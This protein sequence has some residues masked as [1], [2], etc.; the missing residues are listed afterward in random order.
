MRF[1]RFALLSVS[2]LAF[3]RAAETATPAPRDPARIA[4][5]FC[6]NC[7]GQQLLGGSGPNLLDSFWNHGGDEAS[8]LRSI[9]RGYP[10]SGMPPLAEVFSEAELKAMI[11]FIK[12]QGAEFAAGRIKL[13]EAPAA[14]TIESEKALFRLETV[15][16][17]LDMPWGIAFLPNDQIVVTERPGRLRLITKGQLVP[18]PITG[19]PEVF[20][21]QDGGLLD[22]IAHPDYAKNGW[23]YL[24]Y[25]DEGKV[26]NTSMTVV[27]R[28]KIRDGRWVEQQEI[29]RAAPEHYHRSYIHYGC[30][31][32]FD[33]DNHLFFTIGDR[34]EPTEAQDLASPC[35]KIHRVMDDGR[36]PADNPFAKQAGAFGSIWSYGNRHVQ[37][38]QYHPVTGK[39]WATEH[40]PDNG[41][42]LNR[43]EG[44]RNYGWPTISMGTDRRAPIQGTSREG[45]ESPL[46]WWTPAIAPSGIE[47]YAGDKFPQWKN[48]LFVAALAGQQLRRIETDGDRVTHQEV[49]FKG[50]GRVRDVVTGP[51]GFLYVAFNGPGRIARL[52]P[53]T[54][55]GAVAA[56]S[57]ARVEKTTFGQMPDGTDVDIYTL[58]NRHGSFAKILTYGA[59]VA[60][61]RV[62]DRNGRVG[63]VIR[64]VSSSPQMLA[65]GLQNAASIQGRV[66]NRIRNASFTIDG[67]TYK[68]TANNGPHSIHGGV[69]NFS[70]AI[71]KAE[72]ATA[73]DG[74]A[75]KLTYR[76]V[77]GEEGFPGN[78]DV[79]VV[80]TLTGADALRIE[81]TA[82]TDKASPINLT[83]HAYFNLNGFGDVKNNEVLLACDRYTVFDKDLIPT[84][85]I[86]SV[87]GTPFD[88][89]KPTLLAARAAEMGPRPRY[90]QNWVV[91]RPDGDTSLR[92]FARVS[93]PLS[94]RVLEGWTT[95][96]GMQI[97]TSILENPAPGAGGGGGFGGGFGFQF[98]CLETQ[99]HPDSINRPEFPSALLRP[100]QTFRSTTEYR[101]SA[102]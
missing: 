54:D 8:I 53:A 84:G 90:D 101:F 95:E 73:K 59:T 42:E 86:R 66:A 24:A 48:S 6:S 44:G 87:A 50:M 71:W 99:H 77:D 45:M 64:D 72:P 31:F 4:A 14:I 91:N 34:G 100:G 21:H 80:Y 70:R 65:R 39:M 33:K 38:M 58:T 13:P 36:I 9:Q 74:V 32:L 2:L 11:G 94:G 47:F 75:V 88:F 35:G 5:D 22:V 81:Y 10:E 63:S 51:D 26:A 46:A 82:T 93:D 40:G 89:T 19:T 102:K 27:V 23:L 67:Q 3:A 55:K 98:F 57:P 20:L 17:N 30:R 37:G 69:K 60:D 62:P 41:D 25:T 96:P 7:H 79:T 12:Q 29:F 68:V 97:Y 43:I 76:S 85:E 56:Q 18:A 78:M 83:N 52:V 15:V 1:L 28:G 16:P 61:L 49:L 92:F